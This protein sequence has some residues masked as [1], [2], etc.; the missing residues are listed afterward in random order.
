MKGLHTFEDSINACR[1]LEISPLNIFNSNDFRY[2]INIFILC[3]FKM[4]M[5]YKFHFCIY[6]KNTILYVNSRIGFFINYIFKIFFNI[7]IF[8][9]LFHANILY[10]HI[11][12]NGAL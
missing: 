1:I 9:Y 12:Y 7:Y 4:R 10:F 3:Y 8:S 5:I 11:I 2:N 6:N